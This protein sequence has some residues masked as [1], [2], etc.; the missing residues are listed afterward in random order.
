M[1]L[2]TS[3]GV[4][5]EKFGL[6]EGLKVIADA[7]FDG[8][9]F[10]FDIY[11]NWNQIRD[12][13]RNSFLFD[14]EK[15]K[16]FAKEL[17]HVLDKLGLK[18]YQCHAPFPSRRDDISEEFNQLIIESIKNCF[19]MCEIIGCKKLVVHPYNFG[20][21]TNYPTPEFNH[22]MNMKLYVPLIDTIKETGVTCCLENMFIG[23]PTSKKIFAGTCSDISEACQYVDELNEIAGEEIFGFCLDIGHLLLCSIDPYNA[24]KKLGKRIV[25][26]HV[27]DNN[28]L[29]DL[30]VSPYLGICHWDRFAQAVR[31]IGYTDPLDLETGG[32]L[33]NYFREDGMAVAA[34]DM[35][36]AA[37]RNIIKMIEDG[38]GYED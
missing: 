37:G 20:D 2:C 38:T 4:L 35:L 14:L 6:E 19:Y 3:T 13:D 23:D 28:G 24:T 33:V 7:G 12:E 1:K 26:F 10:G 21:V 30:H 31:E 18:P 29:A 8:V 16:E 36:H 5:V 32:M 17:K 11:L 27:H 22:E 9:D 25:C 15:C 34:Y